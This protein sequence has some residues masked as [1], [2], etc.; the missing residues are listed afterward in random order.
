MTPDTGTGQTWRLAGDDQTYTLSSTATAEIASG[1]SVTA[2]SLVLRATNTVSFDYEADA[3]PETVYDVIGLPDGATILA[4]VT[5][6][7]HAGISAGGNYTGTG[8]TPTATIEALDTTDVG[9][10]ITDEFLP[11]K[12]TGLLLEA[13][14]FLGFDRLVASTSVSRDTLAHVEGSIS[15][16]GSVSLKAENTGSISSEVESSFVGTASNDVT[17]DDAVA[18]VNG[19]TLAA[20]TSLI[21]HTDTDHTATAKD[22]SNRVVGMTKATVINSPLTAGA[23]GVSVDA[24]DDSSLTAIAGNQIDVPGTAFVTI[25]NARAQN[26]LDR[27]TEASITGSTV[28]ATGGDV[29]VT[30]TGNAVLS[31]QMDAASIRGKS[32]VFGNN[33][34]PTKAAKAVATTLAL[35]VIKGGVDAHIT[36]GSVTARNVR[37]HAR[38]L[39]ATIDAT[40]QISAVATTSDDAISF[41]L[42][43]ANGNLA[44]GAALALNYVGWDVDLLAFNTATVLNTIDALLGTELRR[45]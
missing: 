5:N 12:I 45:D 15:G 29:T 40:A 35:N 42:G 31:A 41:K 10:L 26:V 13:L 24:R 11:G 25:T 38:T 34:I 21:A 18:T 14:D 36:G 16:V 20:G 33:L 28:T 9:L 43:L 22:S 19:V 17:K 44:V 6:A 37:V 2:P 23:G 3:L 27:T 1:G 30:A 4:H 8:A 39:E 32:A 7:T